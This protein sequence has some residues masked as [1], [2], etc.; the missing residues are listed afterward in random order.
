MTCIK[1]ILVCLFS[2]ALGACAT[3]GSQVETRPVIDRISEAELAKIL[4]QPKATLSLDD[5]VKL[6]K[7]GANAEEVI[8]KIKNSHSFYDLMPSQIIELNKQ[9]VDNK[10]LDYIYTSRELA[11]RNNIADEMNQCKKTALAE[12]EKLKH[13]QN[14]LQNQYMYDPFCGYGHFRFPYRCGSFN[15]GIAGSLGCW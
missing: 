11:L 4:S 9:G 13:Q 10:V 14:L 6:T 3:A 8:E 7:E 1:S 12:L 5:L 15:S 2:I